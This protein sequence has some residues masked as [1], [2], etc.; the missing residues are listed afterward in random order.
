MLDPAFAPGTGTPEPGGLLSRELLTVLGGFAGLRLVGADVVEVA[1][2][3]D[4]A[5]ITGI[6]A[7]HVA[8]ELL[9]AMA[10]TPPAP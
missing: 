2:A 10:L 5:E 9:S 4:H 7:S 8:Y 6:A 3:Y 1:P